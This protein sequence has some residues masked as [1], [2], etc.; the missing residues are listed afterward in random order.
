MTDSVGNG[1]IIIAGLQDMFRPSYW[2]AL[3]AYVLIMLSLRRRWRISE[4]ISSGAFIVGFMVIDLMVLSGIWDIVFAFCPEV[5]T[6]YAP[7]VRTVM[8]LVIFGVGVACLYDWIVLLRMVPAGRRLIPAG[9]LSAWRQ[10]VPLVR[11][12]WVFA[13]FRPGLHLMAGGIAGLIVGTEGVGRDVQYLLFNIVLAKDPMG[14]SKIVLYQIVLTIPFCT[15]LW[16][17]GSERGARWLTRIDS[18]SLSTVQVVLAGLCVGSA[19]AYGAVA[20]QRAGFVF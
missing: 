8:A 18:E 5:E 6:W 7:G 20:L 2:L 11:W 15:V 9:F 19:V 14:L 1:S 17:F 13:I 12:G 4:Q 3:S 10:P 16:L